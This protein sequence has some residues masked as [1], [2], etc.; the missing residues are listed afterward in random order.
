M[1]NTQ[2]KLEAQLKDKRP[3]QLENIQKFKFR[4]KR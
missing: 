2:F 1:K 4:N 3:A